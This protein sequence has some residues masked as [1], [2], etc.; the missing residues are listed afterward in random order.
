MINQALAA[1]PNRHDAEKLLDS[2]FL[3]A[4]ANYY[5]FDERDLRARIQRLYD[6]QWQ[7]DVNDLDSIALALASFALGSQFTQFN[8][9]SLQV[10]RTS[11]NDQLPGANFMY[12]A[13][14]IIPLVMTSCSIESLQCCLLVA[15]CLLPT[16]GPK[17]S[18]IYLSIA[19]KI[20]IS[21]GLHRTDPTPD[22]SPVDETLQ[23]VF[24]T[25]Y[26]IER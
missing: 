22:K 12:H 17:A 13:E 24:W 4:E 6:R 10:G 26:V 16:E 7:A 3:Y 20:A 1:F 11:A 15:I 14:R 8:G 5:Y 18:Y 2:L 23:R 19:L 21:L 9:I 25:T